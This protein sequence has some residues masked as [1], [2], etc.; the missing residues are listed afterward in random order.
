[1]KMIRWIPYAAAVVAL[2]TVAQPA[3]SVSLFTDD[4]FRGQVVT[5]N[6]P[7]NNLRSFRLNDRVSSLVIERGRWQVCD[8]AN[9]AGRCIVLRPGSYPSLSN[10]GLNDRVS[11]VRPVGRNVR[12]DSASEWRGDAAP[13]Y[14]YYRR[15]NER[16]YD[17]R[18]V[19]VRA[20][21]GTPQERC[22]LESTG[23]TSYQSSS[24]S[25]PNVGGAVLGAII[26]GVLGHQ[27]GGGRGRDIATAGGA[28][29]GAAIGSGSF[30]GDGGVTTTYTPGTQVRRCSQTYNSRP[31]YYDVSYEFR[32][33]RNT[34][35]LRDPPGATITVN[36]QGEPRL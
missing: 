5:V 20:V 7:V 1:M 2:P 9:Y 26:G 21:Y 8:D 29:A 6:G 13:V 3:P 35:Q 25:S 22:W 18:V 17:A 36:R 32:G 15:E 19:D 4:G 33:Q 14:R 10:F 31:D 30:S 28:V 11:S 23:A 24:N 12:V 16:L 27:I 34:V